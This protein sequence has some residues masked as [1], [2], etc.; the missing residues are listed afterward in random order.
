[1]TDKETLKILELH[2]S[3]LESHMKSLQASLELGRTLVETLELILTRIDI[4]EET[5]RAIDLPFVKKPD[6]TS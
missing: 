1:M 3:T 4:L 5:V 2:N 6:R